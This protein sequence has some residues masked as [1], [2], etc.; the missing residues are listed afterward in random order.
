MSCKQYLII[1]LLSTSRTVIL[2]IKKF[3]VFHPWNI[4]TGAL[5]RLELF[6]WCPTAGK[7]NSMHNSSN[8]LLPR[9]WEHCSKENTC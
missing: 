4:H 7:R 5:Q 1:F 9:I 2:H 6:Q 8:V 3:L